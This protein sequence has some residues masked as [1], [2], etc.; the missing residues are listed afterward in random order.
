[1]RAVADLA[2]I[3]KA[4]DVRGL[5]PEQL[6]EPTARRIGTAFAHEVIDG[7]TDPAVVIGHDMRSTSP[8]LAGAF[9][10][11]VRATDTDVV[12]I[13]LASTDQLYFASGRLALPGAMF[14]A[15]HNP[16]Q[17]NGIKLCRAGAVAMAADTGLSAIRDRVSTAVQAQT[18]SA[19]RGELEQR[20]MLTSYAEHLL[21][22]VKVTGRRLRVVVDAANGMAG[23]TV[24]PVF[25]ALDVDLVP[26][27]FDLDGSFPNHEA[28]PL[29]PANLRDLQSAVVRE[30]AD[31]GLAFDGDA[32]RCFV[33][34]ELGGLIPP[35]ALT[36]LI[37]VRELQREPGARVVYNLISSRAVPELIVQ[38][39]GV[40]VRTRVGH[41]IIKARMAEENAVFGGEHS[42]HFYFRDF[43]YA[44]SGLLAGLHLLA[45]L[46]ADDRPVSQLLAEFDP[47]KSS[48]EI[49]FSTDRVGQ[50]I[51]AVEAH[52]AENP[53][54]HVDHLDGLTVSAP[55]W[56]FN[57][58]P[59][60]TEPLLRLNVEGV[61][62]ATMAATRDQVMGLLRRSM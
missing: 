48:G 58:R 3:F 4:Y 15:S 12:M 44:D 23:H 35:S 18:A 11:G 24:P 51:E 14:T 39:G 28:N 37:A 46:A 16:A 47:Y 42:G 19:G 61:D 53:Q 1:M 2:A 25:G 54:T 27:Y 50:V 55:D 10:D 40:P 17:Y 56:W 60:N 32:D 7:S 22:T 8:G 41:S 20:D 30:R 52:Y 34:D 29:D 21:G 9:A 26:L 45:A 6:D 43:W 57:I 59:S 13:G 5:V 36:G 31:V 49:N 62:S 33:V 38:N